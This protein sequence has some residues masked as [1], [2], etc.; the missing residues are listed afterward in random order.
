MLGAPFYLMEAYSTGFILRS[1][2]A[3]GDR[4]HTWHLQRSVPAKLSS[5]TWC[6]C[7]R[8]TTQPPDWPTLA[9]P[10]GYLERQVRG[11][12]RTLTSVRRPTAFL[13]SLRSPRGCNGIC[14]KTKYVSLLHNDYK[15]DNVHPG[16]QP[17]LPASSGLLDWGKCAPL[18]DSLAGPRHRARLLGQR[19]LTPPEVKAAQ[20]GPQLHTPV[21]FSRAQVVERYGQQTGRDT[22]R[23]AV[24]TSPSHAFKLAVIIQQIYFRFPPGPDSGSALRLDAACDQC[25]A[26]IIPALRPAPAQFVMGPGSKPYP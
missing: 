5:T 26:R 21:A 17:T 8:S 13:R 7:T 19:G 18:G 4:L 1:P 3:G 9:K 11:W 16:G 12:D 15:Y 22:S 6:V 2:P 25:P 10:E 23:D 14:P 20:L 24:F